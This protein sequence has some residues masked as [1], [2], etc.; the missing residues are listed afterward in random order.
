MKRNNKTRRLSFFKWFYPGI[1][2]KRWILL[3]ILGTLLITTGLSGIITVRSSTVVFP[4]SRTF[5]LVAY[6]LDII[7]GLWLIIQAL[8]KIM[9]TI[10]S[11]FLP[12]KEEQFIDIVYQK[13]QLAKGPKIV[14][15]GGGTG[16]SALLHGLKEFTEH[17]SAIVTVADS[18]GSS[19]RLMKQFDILPPG[20]IRNCL[21]ALADAEPLM[22]Q[23]FQFRFDQDSEFSGHSFGNLF[24]TV[25]TKIT[26]D[27]EKAIKE[28]SKVLAIRGRVI[29]STLS[30]VTLVAKH[31]DGSQTEGEA[32][33]P[34]SGVPIKYVF[35]SPSET[36]AT[37]EA[38]AAIKD[39][40]I[41]I[42]GPGSLYTSI[43]PNL[44][45]REITE[46]IVNSR[47]RKFYVCNIMTQKGETENFTASDHL[48]VIIA[49]S[50]PR[51]VEYCIVNSGSIPDE[52]AKRYQ[53]EN[54]TTVL[55][56]VDKIRSLGY[57]VIVDNFVNINQVV[58]HNSLKLARK[59]I[60]VYN[61]TRRKF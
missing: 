6:S 1:N 60:Q 10:I 42:L 47:A 31:I 53:S 32:N 54:S 30:K 51:I 61:S 23:L 5:L 46:A 14:T 16:L 11:L 44:L 33:I 24:I 52:L 28:S 39:A 49:H 50:H 59:I 34:E 8:K 18:G 9:R 27:F 38:I 58:R 13:K 21:V 41:I 4:S 26:G 57:K 56:D 36:S 22:S 20:D 45:I 35:L 19:G 48:R 12:Q 17:T 29:P 40:D 7:I 25:M 15:I 2:I 55:A 43:I 37:P 3:F